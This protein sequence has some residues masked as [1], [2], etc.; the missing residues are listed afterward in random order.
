MG[1]AAV[2]ISASAQALSHGTVWDGAEQP[3][4][5]EEEIAL[6]ERRI[7]GAA[8][9][10][11]FAVEKGS[12]ALLFSASIV[13]LERHRDLRGRFRCRR[14]RRPPRSC[15]SRYRR[16]LHVV[17]PGAVDRA[18]YKMFGMQPRPMSRRGTPRWHWIQTAKPCRRPAA[19]ALSCAARSRG[20]SRAD[21]P[22]RY[23]KLEIDLLFAQHDRRALTQGQVLKLT[24][25]YFGMMS[26][27]LCSRQR[28]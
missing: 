4:A 13:P 10:I 1:R 11:F 17:G 16:R 26:S 2:F 19:P 23:S 5:I 24:K 14:L 15:P 22:A 20:T 7:G 28:A 3:D 12:G 18:L 21:C 25:R 6:Q 9:R 8:E 27:P